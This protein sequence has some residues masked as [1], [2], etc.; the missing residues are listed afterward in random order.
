MPAPTEGDPSRIGI[1]LRYP[2]PLARTPMSTLL[3]SARDRADG[4]GSTTPTTRSR[5]RIC[6]AA[7]PRIALVCVLL[8]LLLLGLDFKVSQRAAQL[9]GPSALAL[10]PDG[11]Q[12]WLAVDD[13]IWSFDAGGH[14][15]TRARL[16]EIG[17]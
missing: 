5:P 15:G 6:T 16:A 9:F 17:L 13:E 12:A 8:S 4:S 2:C 11:T 10:R 1:G 3:R 7:T 14:R